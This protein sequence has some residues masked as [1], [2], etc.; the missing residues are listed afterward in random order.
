M[1]KSPPQTSVRAPEASWTT[2]PLLVLAVGA[3]SSSAVLVRW[4]DTSSLT[5]SWWR[6]L[7][8][9]LILL[10][11]AVRSW[12]RASA[13]S[14][15]RPLLSGTALAG[16]AL[17]IHFWTWLASLDRTSVAASVALVSTAPFFVIIVSRLARFLP[18]GN[19]QTERRPDSTNWLAITM[20][21]AG[22]IV[23]A[24]AAGAGSG[25]SAATSA[26]IRT[27]ATST[28]GNLL[29]LAGAIAMAVYLTIGD[30]L[31]RSSTTSDGLS[32]AAYAAPVYL[33]AAAALSVAVVA[34]A[35]NPFDLSRSDVLVI[36]AM[37]AG[38]QL[39]GHTVLNHLL[40]RLG[41]L[42]IALVLLAE[43]VGATVLAWLALGEQP[44]AITLAGAGLI[45]CGLALRLADKRP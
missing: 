22:A 6:T 1:V 42:T 37:V 20:T 27:V 7:A 2:W 32:T 24:L 39:C 44:G 21:V 9:G 12:P 19:S 43:P 17:G 35:S 5:L 23:L 31:R 13:G 15:G 28:T 34:T 11:A 25:P 41:A 10:P 16:L 26:E 14:T 18:G 29:A 45:T 8:G 33:A 38:P 3:I 30:R 36:I 40:G 4:A